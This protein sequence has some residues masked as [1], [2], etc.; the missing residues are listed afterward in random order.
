MIRA[1][2]VTGAARAGALALLA[3]ALAAACAARPGDSPAT[4]DPDAT[5]SAASA[6]SPTIDGEWLLV[7]GDVDGEPLELLP[8]WPVTLTIDGGEVGGT[9]ACNGYGG[10]WRLSGSDVAVHDLAI[11]EMFC[12]DDPMALE[13]AYVDAL[14]RVGSAQVSDGLVLIGDD[15]ELTFEAIA[16]VFTDAIV[17]TQWNLIELVDADATIVSQPGEQGFLTLRLAEDGAFEA[18]TGC[19]TLAGVWAESAGQIIQLEARI[20]GECPAEMQAQETHILTVLAGFTPTVGEDGVLTLTSP[21]SGLG[22]RYIAQE[23]RP[24]T[25]PVIEIPTPTPEPTQ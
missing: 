3:F 23:R 18:T 5:D 16:P 10:T 7:A 17:G 11:T 2:S 19:S 22:L 1:R 12:G 8:A 21:L 20:D 9:A 24:L 4:S 15:V 13:S 25:P 14:L 6:A